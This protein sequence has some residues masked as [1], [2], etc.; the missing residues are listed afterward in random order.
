MQELLKDAG[1]EVEEVV[2]APVGISN[3][4]DIASFLVEHVDGVLIGVLANVV[5]AWKR[6]TPVS[7]SKPIHFSVKDSKQSVIIRVEGDGNWIQ[8][9]PR[10]EQPDD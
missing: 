4:V 8:V 10:P 1:F 6:K 9:H 2:E 7:Q 3:V 5:Y